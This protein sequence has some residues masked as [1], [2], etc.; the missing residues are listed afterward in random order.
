MRIQEGSEDPEWLHAEGT[1]GVS[2]GFRPQDGHAIQAQQ[3]V[4]WDAFMGLNQNLADTPG[5]FFDAALNG[6][7]G[8][9]NG[10]G[11]SS[12]NLFIPLLLG[13]MGAVAAAPMLLGGRKGKKAAK[14]HEQLEAASQRATAMITALAPVLALPIGYIAVD[15]LE[16][17]R[18]ISGKLGDR[19]QLLIGS[20]ASG[21]LIGGLL[22]LV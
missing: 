16:N 5:A 15:E 22:K 17:R 11:T 7:G 21:S 4:V 20:L 10:G 19:V 13:G 9:G 2:R 1:T 8:D 14:Q 3:G 18:I 12:R 6:P